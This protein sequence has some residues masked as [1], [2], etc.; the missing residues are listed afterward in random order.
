L[1]AVNSNLRWGNCDTVAWL[2]CNGVAGVD[3]GAFFEE[4][5]DESLLRQFD[6]VCTELELLDLRCGGVVIPHCLVVL[7][8]S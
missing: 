3:T 4:G 1:V 7:M 2:L 5:G 8:R 6:N